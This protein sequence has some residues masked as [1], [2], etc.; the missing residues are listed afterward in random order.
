MTARADHSFC[1]SDL[2]RMQTPDDIELAGPSTAA[3]NGG[4]RVDTIGAAAPLTVHDCW[5]SKTMLSLGINN[6]KVW[7]DR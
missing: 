2:S 7:R 6:T 1:V 4:K 3:R 5:E